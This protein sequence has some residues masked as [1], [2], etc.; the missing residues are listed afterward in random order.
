M[1]N[2]ARLEILG[3]EMARMSLCFFETSFKRVKELALPQ[4]I[5]EILMSE[6]SSICADSVFDY[7]SSNPA[8]NEFTFEEIKESYTSHSDRLFHEGHM[9]LLKEMRN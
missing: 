9:A 8:W 1:G 5:A 6:L 2:E 7:F 4:Q 3:A